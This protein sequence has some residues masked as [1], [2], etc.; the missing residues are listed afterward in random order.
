MSQRADD[1]SLCV[2]DVMTSRPL[3][4]E[5][6]ATAQEAAL[7]MR[8]A[9]VGDV[10]VMKDGVVCGILTDRDIVVR[11]DADGRDPA[12]TMIGEI[13]SAEL[14]EVS[15]DDSVPDVLRLMR[16]R[17]IRRLPVVTN[18]GIPVGVVSLGDLALV[19]D[20]SSVLAGISAAPPNT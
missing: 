6:S 19:R 7:A 10:L 17:A 11:S 20:P 4:L 9:D 1:E 15:P 14:T 13:C 2:R 16:D 12:G 18:D 8:E 5:A 3:T